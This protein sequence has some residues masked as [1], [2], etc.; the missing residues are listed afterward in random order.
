[1]YRLKYIRI[2]LLVVIITACSTGK[3]LRPGYKKLLTETSSMTNA[4]N[5]DYINA[6]ARKYVING[7]SLQQKYKWAESILE[8]QQALRYDSSSAIYY[9]I[10]R[11]YKELKKYNLALENIAKSLKL[12][13][14]FI[15]S[16]E[17]A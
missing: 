6:E 12:D 13:S 3:D 4:V 14:A 16:M 1:M 2:V 17:L 7:S 15:T 11:S 5:S 9:A 8:F 10:A